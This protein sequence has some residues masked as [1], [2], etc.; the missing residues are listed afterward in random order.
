[1][2]V[3]RLGPADRLLSGVASLS[4]TAAIEPSGLHALSFLG[5]SVPNNQH[6]L[7]TTEWVRAFQDAG[8][9]YGSHRS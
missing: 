1:M 7:G 8:E 2:G 4:L 3:R 5:V 9:R 6:L